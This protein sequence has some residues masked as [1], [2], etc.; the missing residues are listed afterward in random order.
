VRFERLWLS[1]LPV[2]YR[3]RSREIWR[4]IEEG[5]GAYTR[6][7]VVESL[8]AGVILWLVT[9]DGLELAAFLAVL[10]ALLLLIPWLGSCYDYPCISSG[11][12]NGLLGA[13][14][15]LFL[16]RLYFYSL[17][18]DHAPPLY[19]QRQVRFYW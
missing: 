4:A 10:A 2:N 17:M 3:S 12:S 5:V 18:C 16:P 14:V 7:Q 9:V 6:R 11:L 19:S 8:L 15:Q 13:S 1:L